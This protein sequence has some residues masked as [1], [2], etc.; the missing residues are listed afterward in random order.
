MQVEER[1]IHDSLI[2]LGLVFIKILITKSID[3]SAFRRLTERSV[4]RCGE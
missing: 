2:I 1:F 4:A 3:K